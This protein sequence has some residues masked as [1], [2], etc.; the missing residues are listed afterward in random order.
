MGR[1]WRRKKGAER[2]HRGLRGRRRGTCEE[3]RM[4]G[5]EGAGGDG[6]NKARTKDKGLRS[7]FCRC[8]ITKAEGAWVNGTYGES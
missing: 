2:G 1:G 7:I 5:L 3:P 4:C 8:S 6:K